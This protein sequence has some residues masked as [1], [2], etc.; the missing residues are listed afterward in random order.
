M[1][2]RIF[3]AIAVV[4]LLLSFISLLLCW[5]VIPAGAQ[6][7]KFTY[8]W[9]ETTFYQ[10]KTM[11]ARRKLPTI[12]TG[13]CLVPGTVYRCRRVYRGIPMRGTCRCN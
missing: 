12:V 6:S 7:R 10:R 2:M 4:A 3:A 8:S 1:Q 11:P 5:G 9:K 13:A